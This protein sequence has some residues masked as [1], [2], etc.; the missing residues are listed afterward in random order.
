MAEQT[1]KQRILGNIAAIN[2][3]LERYPKM[4]TNELENGVE[5]T[6]SAI[7]FLMD[8]LRLFGI[9]EESV[10]RLLTK[11]IS[12]VEENG[13]QKG[14]LFALNEA[15]KAL[16][17][18]YLNGMYDCPIDPMLPDYFLKSPHP[19]AG[20]MGGGSAGEEYYNEGMRIPVEEIDVFGLL[21][22]VP[23]SKNGSVFYFDT[24]G[25][26]PS[27]VYCST[28]MNAFLWYVINR[29]P[30]GSLDMSRNVWDNRFMYSLLFNSSKNENGKE[31]QKRFVNESVKDSSIRFVRG[32]GP[33]YEI[34]LCEFNEKADRRE[35]DMMNIV[36]GTNFLTVHGVSDHYKNDIG[37]PN[38]TI[39]QFNTEYI[40]NLKLFDT[41]TLTASIVNAVIGIS[42]SFSVKFSLEKNIVAKKVEELVESVMNEPE[43]TDSK[44]EDYFVFSDEKYSQ[45]V[46]DATLRYNSQYETGSENGDVDDVDYGQVF[47]AISQIEPSLSQEETEQAVMSALMG[48]SDILSKSG[49]VEDNDKY[50]FKL[51]IISGFIKEVIVQL[52]MQV[53]TPKVMLIFAINNRFLNENKETMSSLSIEGFFKE[54]WNVIKACIKKITEMVM[55]AILEMVIGQIKPIIEL[56]IKKLLL[57]TIMYY[58]VLLEQILRNCSMMP[59]ITV[60]PLFQYGELTIDNVDYADIIPTETNPKQ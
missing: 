51:S 38:K 16:L 39:Y 15:I 19:Q 2:T 45:I 23:T 37:L 12:G 22:N 54:F 56:V 24:S 57:E 4:L 40:S 1:K 3:I 31:T 55:G 41:K 50:T 11:L 21:Q 52:C 29:G 36:N 53:L 59:M 43:G 33:K 13:A 60:N 35:G 20:S 44:F 18:A 5:N 48:V 32:V 46:N 17:I 49:Y 25:F 27:D 58:R 42:Q 28:D 26:T 7:S 10:L 6:F 47:D 9:T 30:V 34:L 8:I 14:M